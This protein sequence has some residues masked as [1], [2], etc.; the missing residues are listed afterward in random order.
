MC[1][2]RFDLAGSVKVAL[3]FFEG[4]KMLKTHYESNDLEM[5]WIIAKE[6]LRDEKSKNWRNIEHRLRRVGR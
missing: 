1:Q 5:W 6:G 2:V 3:C 4:V